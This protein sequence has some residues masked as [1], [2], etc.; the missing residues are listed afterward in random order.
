MA[1]YQQLPVKARALIT[2]FIWSSLFA[3]SPQ[4]PRCHSPTLHRERSGAPPGAGNSCRAAAPQSDFPPLP[5]AGFSSCSRLLAGNHSS[6][7]WD[8]CLGWRAL[9]GSVDKSQVLPTAAT[10]ILEMFGSAELDSCGDLWQLLAAES[11]I[12]EISLELWIQLP[13]PRHLPPDSVQW[14]LGNAA[15]KF[16]RKQFIT[17]PLNLMTLFNEI[18][19]QCEVTWKNRPLN[20]SAWSSGPRLWLLIVTLQAEA[21]QA[22]NLTRRV[23]DFDVSGEEA[24]W[25]TGWSRA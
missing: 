25:A 24:A 10:S 23:S 15:G 6:M 7:R 3:A 9:S 14:T 11:A 16:I 20:I 5:A 19:V 22:P 18:S 1:N 4:L 2:H 13:Q 17:L 12:Q 8:S 21:R